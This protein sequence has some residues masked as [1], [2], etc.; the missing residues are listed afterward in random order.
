MFVRDTQKALEELLQAKE[1]LEKNVE[2]NQMNRDLVLAEIISEISRMHMLM[3]KYGTALSFLDDVR[4]LTENFEISE[5]IIE[6]KKNTSTL[7]MIIYKN[8]GDLNL[9]LK[10][11]K[12]LISFI[13]KH[14]KARSTYELA[15]AKEFVAEI[16]FLLDDNTQAMTNIQLALSYYREIE[17]TQYTSMQLADALIFASQIYK[18][19]LEI[20]N[21][22]AFLTEALVIYSSKYDENH[23]VVGYILLQLSQIYKDKA[24]YAKSISHGVKALKVM[25]IFYYEEDDNVIEAVKNLSLI[26]K[27]AEDIHKSI[28]L[29]RESLDLMDKNRNIDSPCLLAENLY[30]LGLCYLEVND[31]ENARKYLRESLSIY[32]SNLVEDD[33]I[34]NDILQKLT[35]VNFEMTKIAKVAENNPIYQEERSTFRGSVLNKKKLNAQHYDEGNLVNS[36]INLADV[37]MM[38]NEFEKSLKLYLSALK[39]KKDSNYHDSKMNDI[40]MKIGLIYLIAGKFEESLKYFQDCLKFICDIS[41][42]Q[43]S[44]HIMRLNLIISHLYVIL[45]QKPQA[46]EHN[47]KAVRILTHLRKTSK[48][49]VRDELLMNHAQQYVSI[50]LTKERVL[51][52]NEIL[53]DLME[54]LQIAFHYE[55]SEINKLDSNQKMSLVNSIH[56]AQGELYSKKGIENSV[57]NFS[58]DHPPT[59]KK[60]ASL[61]Y[62]SSYNRNFGI[63]LKS[64]QSFTSSHK[65]A[66]LGHS[67]ST[68]RFRGDSLIFKRNIFLPGEKN[69]DSFFPEKNVNNVSNEFGGRINGGLK[70]E[71]SLGNIFATPKSMNMN[72]KSIGEKMGDLE[73]VRNESRDEDSSAQ[74]KN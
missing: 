57:Q 18:C 31:Y 53:N 51:D 12:K 26:Y 68:P 61:M 45:D 48:T 34:L 16:Y 44:E 41:S 46:L 7:R 13:E 67:G 3:G 2:E 32:N 36:Y 56:Q 58:N 9:A 38:K 5:K 59:I 29:L 28:Y 54:I 63:S 42:D 50:D 60:M 37:L 1:Y 35:V 21:S 71:R 11:A 4:K 24:N 74:I 64:P 33:L 40:L 55:E 70:H 22:E 72:K 17:L 19:L 49:I 14:D 39:I 73:E 30:N 23:P 6:L 52:K 20:E 43:L 65:G 10:A 62:D 69:N 15:L 8:K 66:S 47:E 25:R 27:E